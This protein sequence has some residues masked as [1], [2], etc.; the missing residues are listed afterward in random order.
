MHFA[1]SVPWLLAIGA[2]GTWYAY[3]FRRARV[4]GGGRGHPPA[5]AVAFAAGLLGVAAATVS[6]LEHYGNQALWVDFLGFLVLTMVAAPMLLLGA[7]LTLAFRRAGPAGRRRLRAAYRSRAVTVLTFPVF[8]WL[9]FAVL[10]YL[11]QF[12]RLTEWAADARWVRDVQLGS[13][14]AVSLLFWMPALCAD[15]M[16]W[17]MAY[18]LRALYV[19]VEMT[20]KGLFGGM[21]L[22][23]S[24]VFHPRFAAHA[25]DWAPGA[26]MDQRVAIV[27]L[28]IGGNMVFIAALVGIV[29]G[30]IRYES[31][32]ARRTDQRLARAREAARQKRAALD[33]VFGRQA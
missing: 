27:I 19:F 24:H 7:P 8:T 12:T 31:R 6:P 18:P 15:P 23:M 22:S 14:L 17:R 30:W 20:H 26:M 1:L 5:R 32:N 4:A 25:A 13:L 3:A 11:W 2:A 10:T 21:F 28:W 33:S 29:A 16:R 9:A